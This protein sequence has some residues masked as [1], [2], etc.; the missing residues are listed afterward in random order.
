MEDD[1][2]RQ[3]PKNVPIRC[4]YK[5]LFYSILLWSGVAFGKEH[6]ENPREVSQALRP[7]QVEV[8]QRLD[9]Q[10]IQLKRFYDLAINV[11]ISELHSQYKPKACELAWQN[12]RQAVTPKPLLFANS[13][14][15]KRS[16]YVKLREMAY[17]NN[18]IYLSQNK[19]SLVTRNYANIF[20]IAWNKSNILA[21]FNNRKDSVQLMFTQL[22]WPSSAKRPVVMSVVLDKTEG[23]ISFG[24]NFLLANG[25]KDADQRFVDPSIPFSS[26]GLSSSSIET[27][28]PGMLADAHSG[29]FTSHGL[30]FP[31]RISVGGNKD[32]RLVITPVYDSETEKEVACEVKFD[33]SVDVCG[34]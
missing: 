25:L 20:A 10:L 21:D 23:G 12:I 6:I 1:G 33:C 22:D 28:G 18:K 9:D 27:T 7:T 17:Y 3:H 26:W 24:A 4:S 15:Q 11:D 34:Y 8:M 30:I 19:K 14:E 13:L 29:L 32:W 16:L 5:S 2:V 31:W